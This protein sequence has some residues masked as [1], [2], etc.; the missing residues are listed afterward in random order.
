MLDFGY[1]LRTIREARG[2]SQKDLALRINRSIPAISGYESNKQMPPGDVLESLAMALNVSIDYLIGFEQGE[3]F[4]TKSL[5]DQQKEIVR[6]LFKEFS[7]PSSNGSVLSV[8]QIEI[9]Q[10]LIAYFNRS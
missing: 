9:I 3:I 8:Q 7:K 2:L 5:S 4:T 1:R 6:L 10:K